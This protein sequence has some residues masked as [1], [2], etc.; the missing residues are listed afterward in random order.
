M[1]RASLLI[2][3]FYLFGCAKQPPSSIAFK[4]QGREAIELSHWFFRGRILVKS[5]DVVNAN[6]QWRHTVDSELLSLSGPLGFGKKKILVNE[7][8]VSLDEGE[9]F[10]T[11]ASNGDDFIAQQFGIFVPMK[12]LSVWI[13]GRPLIAKDYVVLPNGFEQLGWKII[14]DRYKATSIGLMP[15]KVKASKDKMKLTLIVEHWGK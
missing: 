12:A 5:E 10:Q 1:A 3:V 7:Y 6:I 9:G 8:G 11:I 15:H 14:Y 13:T 2:M 4:Q